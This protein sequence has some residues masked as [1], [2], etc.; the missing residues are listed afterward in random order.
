MKI[1]ILAKILTFSLEKVKRF[2]QL[3]VKIK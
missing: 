1:A 2:R 3:H